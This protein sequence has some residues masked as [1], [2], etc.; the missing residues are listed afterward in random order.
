M[1]SRLV[2]K[3]FTIS[4]CKGVDNV[5]IYLKTGSDV[6]FDH[7]T[8]ISTSSDHFSGL[9]ASNVVG[10]FSVFNSSFLAP[11]GSNIVVEYSICNSPSLYNFSSNKIITEF[12]GAELSFEV[13]CSNVKIVIAESKFQS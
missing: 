5:A 3:N 6:S 10:I 11:H 7:V 8:T 4:S 1:F 12:Y 9:T 13:F 2:I